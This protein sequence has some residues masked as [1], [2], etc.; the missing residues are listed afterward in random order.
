MEFESPNM[1]QSWPTCFPACLKTAHQFHVIKG[2]VVV[3]RSLG[4]SGPGKSASVQIYSTQVDTNT[5][6]GKLSKRGR[7][8]K[9]KSNEHD[10][11][12]ITY[13]ITFH[14]E[15]QF[16]IPGALLITNQHKHEFFLISVMLDIPN[17]RDIHFDCNSWVYPIHKTKI[18]RVFFSNKCYLP[19]HTPEALRE[20]RENELIGLRGD[21]TGERKEWERIYDYDYYNDLGNPD[22]GWSHVRPILGGSNEHPYPRRG[23]T[24]RPPSN[25]DV[26]TESRP[27]I[28]NL[29]IYVPPDER[30]SPRKMSEFLSNSIQAIVHFLIPEAKSFFQKDSNSF[31][32]F[33]E[34]R[35]MFSGSAA[36][37]LDRRLEA[38]LKRLVPDKVFG[39]IVRTSKENPGKFPLPQIISVNELAWRD[40]EEFGREMLAGI[41]PAV[42]RSLE[43][44]PPISKS[45]KRSSI[46]AAHIENNLDGLTIK[47][48]MDQWRIFI[49]DHHDYLMPF[50]DR[51]NGQGVCIYASR[52]LLFLRDNC[53]LKP[54]AIELSLPASD[55]EDGEISRVFVPA[56]E[57]MERA[58][59]QLAKAHVAVNDSSHHQL[60]SHWLHT[61]AVVEPFIIATR[62]QLSSMHPIHKLLNPHF[63]DTMHINALARSIIL[64]A[65]GILERTMFPGKFSMELSSALYKQWR[66]DEQGLPA[67]L[68]KR[69]LAVVDSGQPSGVRL[70]FKDYPYGAD[71]LDIW[72]AI[73]TWVSDYCSIFYLDDNAVSSDNEIQAWWNEI[74]Q[75]GHGDKSDEQWWYQ[76]NTLSNLIQTLTT[77]IWIA[78]ALHASI[79]FGQYGYAGYPPNRP[80][81]CRKFIPE[82]GTLEYAEFLEDPDK[83]YLK[84]LPDRFV[85]TLGVALTEVLSTHMSDEV[86]VGQRSSSEWTDNDDVCRIFDKFR[87]NLE[88]VEKVIMERNRN[89][90]LKNR[91][92]P[93]RIPYMLLYPDT[94]K[95]GPTKGITGKGIPNSISI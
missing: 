61:H 40:D 48:A 71:G 30:F 17:S 54:L 92:G 74:R 29:D 9:D 82:E 12:T 51:I 93:A 21:R 45:G 85:T 86:Y 58:L 8:R 4:R 22:K 91:L 68:I 28:I 18:G 77:L 11:S 15:P 16:G 43:S 38:M 1:Q 57:G 14:V 73:K 83:Y 7:L 10:T 6:T 5:E 3:R 67:D 52:M 59:W 33:D 2:K 78:S 94:S 55:G 19:D 24:G 79:N 34:M 49:L 41:N 36:P 65:D 81:M 53:T 44:F 62:R 26:R 84:M 72:T 25:E 76:M 66:F 47:G 88:E 95:V 69:R 56:P 46:T 80:T 27:S 75:V 35:N 60:I 63:K 50:L 89:A 42:I 39:E 37:A 31:E 64:S 13:R 70:L 20:L 23:R 32:S 90:S 87:N